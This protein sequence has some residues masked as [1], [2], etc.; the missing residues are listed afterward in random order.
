MSEFLRHE[1]PK[2]P[3]R[4][5]SKKAT[6]PEVQAANGLDTE[7][8]SLALE[9]LNESVGKIAHSFYSHNVNSCDG[10]N[11]LNLFTGVNSH[12]LRLVLEGDA[13]SKI[14]DALRRIADAVEKK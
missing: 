11:S 9:D 12:P 14:A 7:L 3:T 2:K 13:V 4:T 1:Q 5:P 8:L 6:K 10:N